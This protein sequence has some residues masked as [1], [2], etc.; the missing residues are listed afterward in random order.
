MAF[1]IVKQRRPSPWIRPLTLGCAFAVAFFLSALLLLWQG[2]SP[3]VAL[4]LFLKSSFGSL[5][6][7]TDCLNKTIPIFLCSLGVAIAFRLQFWNIGAEGQYALGA[8]GATW[9]ALT[10]PNLPGPLLLPL[11]FGAATISGGLWGLLACL[12]KIH[13]RANEIITT[14]MLNYIGIL[15]LD[16]LVYGIWKDPAS[17]GFPM[18]AIFSDAAILKTIPGTS[19]NLGLII[20]IFCGLLTWIFLNFTRLGYELKAGGENIKAALYAHIPYTKLAMLAMFISGALAGWAGLFE[21]SATLNRL[22]PSVLAGYGYT[23]IIVAWLSRLSPLRIAFFSF[24]LA[25]ILV[26]V[27]GIQLEM[28]TPAAFGQ[29]VQGIILLSVLCGQFFYYYRFKRS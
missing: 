18:T 5:W 20:C 3:F 24:L 1:K 9:A 28:Q 21:T 13:C 19:L 2:K 6:A 25:S 16:L 4:E 29:I 12:L 15:L 22:Q 17:F 23:A 8:I 11:M 26:G 7:I 10:F 27:D 14:L